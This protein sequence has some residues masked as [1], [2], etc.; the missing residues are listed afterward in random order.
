MGY[1]IAEAAV[2]EVQMLHYFSQ[3]SYTSKDCNVIH[4]TT[5]ENVQ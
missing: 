2:K 5:T 4:V 3:P 1:A